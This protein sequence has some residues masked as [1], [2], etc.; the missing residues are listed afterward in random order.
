MSGGV[1]AKALSSATRIRVYARL[2]M[3]W[4]EIPSA[5]AMGYADPMSGSG[6]QSHD[7]MCRKGKT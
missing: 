4:L 6:I 7:L 5:R 3:S 2:G 1:P